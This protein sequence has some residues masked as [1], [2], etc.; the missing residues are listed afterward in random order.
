ML[1]DIKCEDFEN[2]QGFTLIFQFKENQPFFT[3]RVLTKCYEVPN[4]LLE[5]EPMLKSVKG[6]DIDWKPDMC[7]TFKEVKKKQRSKSGKRASQMRTITKKERCDSFF[8]FFSI[9]TVP[10]LKL[11]EIGEEEANAIEEVF[12]HDYVVAQSFRL[13]IIPN[14]VLWFTGEAMQEEIENIVQAEECPK[15]DPESVSAL[16]PFSLSQNG[17]E[18][19][20]C[21]QN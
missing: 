18:E 8:H 10:N 19:P 21:K 14:A 12:D 11:G 13:H 6:C 4:L 2:G 15:R 3:N 17:S 16:S 1:E 5:D 9:P 7:L 20:E